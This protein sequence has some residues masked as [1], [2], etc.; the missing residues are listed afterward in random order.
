MTR[1][2]LESQVLGGTP[3]YF[4]PLRNSLVIRAGFAADRR[5]A[6]ER[7][8]REWIEGIRRRLGLVAVV[9]RCWVWWGV[10]GTLWT[11][12]CYRLW[13]PARGGEPSQPEAFAAAL[14]H[15]R[16]FIPEPPEEELSGELDWEAYKALAVLAVES[17]GMEF[18]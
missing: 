18:R 5:A 8:R 15:V 11:W 4:S 2:E 6:E 7:D 1:A 3:I 14:A 9:H 13:C 16:S 17:E 12:W 10:E